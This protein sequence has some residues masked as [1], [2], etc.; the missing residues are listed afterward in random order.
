MCHPSSLVCMFILVFLSLLVVLGTLVLLFYYAQGDFT[1][2]QS[3]R[4]TFGPGDTQNLFLSPLFCEQLSPSPDASYGDGF[5]PSTLYLLR[6]EPTLMGEASIVFQDY[7][8]G[9]KQQNFHFYPNSVIAFDVCT[10]SSE[11][12]SFYLIKSQ[13]LYLEWK[14]K[15]QS[16][17]QHVHFLEVSKLCS[18]GWQSFNYTVE[19]E[20]QYYLLFINSTIMVSYDIKRTVYKFDASTVE[21]S[22]NF[23]TEAS[24]SVHV[25]FKISAAALL[26]YGV[27]LDWGSRW[28]NAAIDVSCSKQRVWMYTLLGGIGV[29]LISVVTICS[30]VLCCCCTCCFSTKDDES[31]KPLLNRHTGNLYLEDQAS[32]EMSN[33]SQDGYQGPPSPTPHIAV[34]MSN[35]SPHT[36]PP[37]FKFSLGTPTCETF[38]S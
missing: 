5:E 37:N 3:S 18:E 15:P 12:G 34:H 32:K 31:S 23:T 38:T 36:P 13:K 28:N 26:V 25:P 10:N 11:F 4:V 17:P 29:L 14:S 8:N 9:N 16:E 20:D 7:L 30:C 35:N 19:E 24:C 21:T 1:S 6:A 33:P 22:C 27:P 2:T